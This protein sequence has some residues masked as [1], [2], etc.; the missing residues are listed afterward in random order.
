MDITQQISHSFD[1]TQ[2]IIVFNIFIF[3]MFYPSIQS[4][5]NV[6]PAASDGE[7]AIGRIIEKVKR[8]FWDK[9][10]ILI[11]SNCL[12]FLLFLPVL[13]SVLIDLSQNLSY[14]YDTYSF[15]LIFLFILL[16]FGWSI[17][18]TYQILVKIKELGNLT[19]LGT[20]KY[21]IWGG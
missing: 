6:K 7:K 16:F 15:L 19:H 3:T 4:K 18:L 14:N 12:V 17:K 10:I 8:T 11:L 2:I 1:A 5:I 21:I 9:C 13:C 20:I